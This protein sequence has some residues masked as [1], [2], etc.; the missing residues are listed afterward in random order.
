MPIDI[1]ADVSSLWHLI[2]D[3]G[4]ADDDQLNAAYDEHKESAK[5]FQDCL[6]NYG[7]VGEEQL[8]LMI[9]DSIGSEYINI[10]EYSMDPELLEL[11][12][13]SVVKMYSIIPIKVEGDE[14]YVA[15][16]DPMNFH[17]I[18][19][20]YQV[21]GRPV[22]I[23]VAKPADIDE[24]IENYYPDTSLESLTEIMEGM[25]DDFDNFGWD[26]DEG[27]MDEA[28]IEQ[29][30][31]LTPIVRFVNV[32]LYQAVKDQASDIHFEP[33]SD[34]FRIRYRVDGVLYEMAPPPKHLAIPVISR[35]KVVSGLNIAERRRP[36]DGRMQMRIAGKKIDLRV[37]TLP[38]QYGE[39]LVLRILDKT[40]VN[41]DLDALGIPDE[42]KVGLRDSIRKPNGIILVTGPTGSG[43]TTTLY[44]CLKE[45]NNI[46]DKIL[47]AEDP[48]EYT[49]EG[50]MQV[51]VV[52][53]VGMTFARALKA[54]LRQDPDRIMVG[55]IRD[56]ETAG[57]SIEAAL[58]GHIVLSTLHTN[59]SASAITR[60][61][62]MGIEPFL[63]NSTV[64]AVLAQRLVRS[65]C[66]S[67]KTQYEI[68][69]AEL[70]ALQIT[71][72][73]WG[74]NVVFV[75]EGCDSCNNTGYK[76]R[77]GV[78]EWL[79]LS[80]SLK[81]MVMAKEAASTMMKQAEKEGMKTLRSH[82]V[83]H[84]LEGNTSVEEVLKYT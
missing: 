77:T 11:V 83:Q 37:S 60:L 9:A 72:E 70:V 3:S 12:P 81:K 4:L 45:I 36:Q 21:L 84:V 30:A 51:P 58:T 44:S 19:E 23:V 49:I 47:T 26:E 33:F 80:T 15:A 74:D 24:A 17:L 1:D 50:L 2:S 7:I 57:I 63:L 14:L 73:E 41:L 76:G 10:K 54:F 18:D 22:I 6:Y 28:E 65:I 52:E 79:T 68:T 69:E 67:C 55:E 13:N 46:E 5:S 61:I 75:G 71:R 38:T 82:A 66:S 35:V 59:D 20:L 43:K 25:G 42:I 64:E 56:L 31:N 39:S 78:Y 16:S 32:V 40:V 53:S 29:A 62:D 34:Q 8:L 48:V 27:E